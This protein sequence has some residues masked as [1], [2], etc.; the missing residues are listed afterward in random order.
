MTMGSYK[1]QYDIL[2][3]LVNSDHL[4]TVARGDLI[5]IVVEATIDSNS[6]DYSRGNRLYGSYTSF[7]N[8]YLSA[9]IGTSHKYISLSRIAAMSP[10]E[11]IDALLGV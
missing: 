10:T 3:D 2:R 5:R 8:I 6:S 11:V 7:D 9:N 1:S 4:L